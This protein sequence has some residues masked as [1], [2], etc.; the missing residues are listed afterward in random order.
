[1]DDF[2]IKPTKKTIKELNLV[3]IIDMFTTVI[4]FLLLST[5][6]MTLS[7]LTVPPSKV[8]TTSSVSN[9]MPV[10]PKLFLIQAQDGEKLILTWTGQNPGRIL[11]QVSPQEWENNSL[12]FIEKVK[13]T[14]SEFKKK[15]PLEKSIQIGLGKEVPY[16]NLISLMDGVKEIIPDLVLISY[17]EVDSFSKTS[18]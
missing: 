12:L 6:F 7:K 9:E 17:Q 13:N 4:F 18:L 15:F 3:P 2:F 10:S 16:Q 5:T 14:V 11:V 1:M 8:S